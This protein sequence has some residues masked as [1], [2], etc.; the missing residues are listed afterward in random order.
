MSR[1]DEEYR[2]G[3]LASV[4]DHCLASLQTMRSFIDDAE[5]AIMRDNMTPEEMIEAV[6]HKVAWGWANAT[7][8]PVRSLSALGDARRI[9]E[10]IE[11]E[12]T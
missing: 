9:Q 5:R 4:R 12:R 2:A 3:R 6:V 11:K 7:S 10:Q 1:I 8:G